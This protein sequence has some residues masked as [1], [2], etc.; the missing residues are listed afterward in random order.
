MSLTITEALAE[1]KTVQ[2]RIQKKREFVTTYLARQERMKDPLEK[3]GGSFTAIEKERQAISDLEQRVVD[4]RRAVYNA[5]TDTMVSVNGSARSI[6]DWLVWRRE[7]A[8]EHRTFL[9]TLRGRVNAVRDEA[10]RKG[11]ALIQGNEKAL[12]DDDI[13]VNLNEQELANDIEGLEEVLGT[14]DGKLSLNNA[15]VT[16][17]V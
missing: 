14:L 4:L 12:A 17:E 6:A 5:N 7:I 3:Q 9:E 16:I 10:Q 8:P 2:K 11:L 1:I 15:L 13:I